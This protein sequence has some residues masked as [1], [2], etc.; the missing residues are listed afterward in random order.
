MRVLVSIVGFL[1]CSQS[2]ST[3]HGGIIASFTADGSAFGPVSINVGQTT[4]VPLYLWYDGNGTNYLDSPGLLSAGLGVTF[5]TG[6]VN[7]TSET[8]G[9][10]WNLDPFLSFSQIDNLAGTAGIVSGLDFS[11]PAVTGSESILIGTLTFTGILAGTT[12]LTLGDFSNIDDTLVNDFP[13][14]TV[15]DGDITFGRTADITVSGTAAVPEPATG[16]VLLLGTGL[17]AWRRSRK[18]R[19]HAP[20]DEPLPADFHQPAALPTVKDA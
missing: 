20:R 11:D 4:D 14:N 19:H 5:N 9:P 17:L 12:T 1:L 18:C 3:T 7:A 16:I 6:V 13:T 10:G 15:L 2:V 8:I